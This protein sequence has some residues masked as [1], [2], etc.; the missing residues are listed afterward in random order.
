[1]LV[2]LYTTGFE[3]DD[4]DAAIERESCIPAASQIVGID[5]I[6]G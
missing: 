4:L 1:M 5:N 2:R 3:D 6:R